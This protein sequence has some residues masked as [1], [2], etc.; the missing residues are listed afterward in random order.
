[1]G[2]M[3]K[4]SLWFPFPPVTP[5]GR[6]SSSLDWAPTTFLVPSPPPVLLQVFFSKHFSLDVGS[7]IDSFCL[8]KP[9]IFET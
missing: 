2:C 8:A 3:A 5:P 7:K 9:V 1:M 4:D 6:L